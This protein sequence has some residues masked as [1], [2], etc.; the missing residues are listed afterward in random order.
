LT[1]RDFRWVFVCI[2]SFR[3]ATIR[4]KLKSELPSSGPIRSAAVMVPLMMERL[5]ETPGVA[6]TIRAKTR[7]TSVFRIETTIMVFAIGNFPV[8]CPVNINISVARIET[9]WDVLLVWP[10]PY[11]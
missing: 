2:S 6:C 7:N 5:T 8:S 10:L 3:A 4:K 9:S 11:Q 1:Q